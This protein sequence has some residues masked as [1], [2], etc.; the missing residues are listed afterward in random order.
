MLRWIAFA[1][2]SW[3]ILTPA[4]RADFAADARAALASS[5]LA[6]AEIGLRVVRLDD[7]GPTVVYSHNADRQ[8]IPA[9]NQKLL[10]TS[11]ALDLL[12]PEFRFRTA[13]LRRGDELAI[14]GDG[15][16][17][18]GDSEFLRDAG[19]GPTTLFERWAERLA[20][21]GIRRVS[22]VL[23]DDS[24]FDEVFLHPAWPVEQAHKAYVAQVAGLN[25]NANCLDVYLAPDG[26]RVDV[27]LDPPTNY[28]N[29]SNTASVGRE[30]VLWLTRVMKT[31]DVKIGGTVSARN[32]IPWRV[33]IHD[34][35]MYAGAVFAETLVSSNI[36]VGRIERDRTIRGQLL[37]SAG[38]S[39]WQLIDTYETPIEQ[40]IWQTNKES[41]NLYAEALCKRIAAISGQS[42]SW[43]EGTQRIYRYVTEIAGSSE[44]CVPDDGSGMSRANRVT[45][46]GIAAVLAHDFNGPHREMFVQSLAVGGEDGTLSK[47]FRG[48]LSGRVFAKTGYIRGVSAL[49]GYVRTKG[50]RWYAFSVLVNCPENA[51]GA[52]KRLQERIV[53]AIDSNEP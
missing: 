38:S 6:R 16:P 39:G 26:S 18:L 8:L 47:R 30:Q 29:V 2:L 50:D 42:G 32:R 40:V 7:Q 53:E 5:D 48:D 17:T 15:D 52:A 46:A 37:Q 36:S 10:T 51:I 11:A 33:T 14:V 21:L 35:A 3:T 24:V 34:P 25:L 22:R 1:L 27:R 13:L 43:P 45:A 31:N 9:S 19:W 23:V 12:G 28:V 44:A 20:E 49:S 4:V 41:N